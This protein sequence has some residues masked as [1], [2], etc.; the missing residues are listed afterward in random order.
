ME[1]ETVLEIEFQTVFDKWAW[2]IT[3][4]NEIIFKRG[5]FKDIDIRVRSIFFPDFNSCD[6]I[7]NIRGT[8]KNKDDEINIC[9][10][11]EKEIIERKSESYQ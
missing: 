11:E 2:R 9:T 5:E 3:N 8:Y 6:E 10:T 7:L 1:K 4:Q